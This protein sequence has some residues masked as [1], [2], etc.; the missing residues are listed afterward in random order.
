MTE[1]T[2]HPMKS[3]ES[4][5]CEESLAGQM[6]MHNQNREARESSTGHQQVKTLAVLR[7]DQQLGSGS[8]EEPKQKEK[9]RVRNLDLD[10]RESAS[11]ARK[12]VQREKAVSQANEEEGMQNRQNSQKQDGD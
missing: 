1:S 4:P 8:R 6:T 9:K 5:V 11:Q 3:P 2:I 10:F 7:L 12:Q